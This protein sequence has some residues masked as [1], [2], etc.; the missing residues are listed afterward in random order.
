MMNMLMTIRKS[1]EDA[2]ARV[3]ERPASPPADALLEVDIDGV[4]RR[5]AVIIRRRPPYPNEIASLRKQHLDLGS[6]GAPMLVAPYVSPGIGATITKKGW[7]WADEAGNADLR[8]PQF[9]IQLRRGKPAQRRTHTRSIPGGTGA[10]RIIRFLV[11]EAREDILWGPTELANIAQVSQPRA[12][13]VLAQLNSAGLTSRRESGWHVNRPELLDAFLRDYRGPGGTETCFYSFRSPTEL[14]A[15]L[16]ELRPTR[17]PTDIAISADVGP[18]LISPWRSPSQVVVYAQRSLNLKPLEMTEAEGRSDAT[19]I[20]RV[21]ADNTVFRHHPLVG[22][23]GLH[24][25]PLADEIQMIWDLHDLGGDDR[26][27]A[28]EQLRNW[29]LKAP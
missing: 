22:H 7:S 13:Q 23:I 21:P 14:A 27:Q 28:A 16:V 3:R 10:L 19:L 1:L 12:S 15:Q 11:S 5:F 25:I 20:L 2:G 17:R 9:R 24:E 6:R 4:T 29:I 18:D 26:A 8:A